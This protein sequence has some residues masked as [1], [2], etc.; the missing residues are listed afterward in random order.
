MRLR[1]DALDLR[2]READVVAVGVHGIGEPLGRGGRQDLVAD[3]LNIVVAP[4]LE[5]GRHGVG[6]EQCGADGE[7]Q[8]LAERARDAED[9][10]LV[11]LVEP[12]AGLDLDRGHAL[13]DE[14][15]GARERE[16]QEVRSRSRRASRRRSRRCRRPLWRCPR[17]S[18]PGAAARIRGSASR[19]TRGG[20]G[21]R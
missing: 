10:E 9:L 21:S 8:A 12:V 2:G 13:G 4:V 20:C 5:L 19:P 6:G 16:R 1:E 11:V 14:L 18:R 15:G 3:T 17:S 7:R